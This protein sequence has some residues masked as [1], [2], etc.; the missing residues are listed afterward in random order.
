MDQAIIGKFIADLR[1]QNNMTQEKFAEILGVNSRSV[2]RWENGRCM[3]DLSLLQTIAEELGVSVTELLNG[4]KSTNEEL[5]D[6][7]DT[8]NEL[9]DYSSAE[10]KVKSKKLNNYF[11]MGL[12]CLVIVILNRQ[13]DL[14]SYIFKENAADFVA[15]GLTS[16]GLLFEFIGLYNN[17]HDLAFKDKKKAV[18]NNLIK[19]NKGTM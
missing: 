16:I 13:F 17:N 18:I 7:R 19:T 1:K 2:S 11:I 6:M 12:L 14:L 8:I 9:I 3:P 4:R 15:G 10:K 5:I